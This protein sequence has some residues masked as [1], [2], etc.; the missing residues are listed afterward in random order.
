MNPRY[1]AVLRALH[2]RGLAT[3]GQLSALV[4]ADRTLRTC[5]RCLK[6]LVERE[7]VAAISLRHGGDL[8]GCEDNAYALTARGATLITAEV[9]V[10]PGTRP[11]APGPN[12]ADLPSRDGRL[13]ANAFEILLSRVLP[14]HGCALERWELPTDRQ[15]RY[16]WKG[17]WSAV[18]FDSL[19]LIRAQFRRHWLVFVV[20][21]GAADR[22]RDRWML[23]T[24]VRYWLAK[25]WRASLPACPELRLI[26]QYARRVPVLCSLASETLRRWPEA[27]RAAVDGELSIAVT[28]QQRFLEDPLGAI[29]EPAPRDPPQL[30]SLLRGDE[31]HPVQ[32]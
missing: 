26:C 11:R 30:H 4:F 13:A 1:L 27:D 22:R 20:D 31:L 24:Y 10:P 25:A 29:W 5:Q 2:R 12:A 3:T 9:G 28:W 6:A 32:A 8:G 19:A 23:G 18:R 21:A 17:G 7:L 14:A 15:L 16:R